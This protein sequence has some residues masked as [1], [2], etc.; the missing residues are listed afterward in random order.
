MN[1]TEKH[2]VLSGLSGF[3][4]FPLNFF[5]LLNRLNPVKRFSCVIR[6]TAVR[7]RHGSLSL[8]QGE[9]RYRR[10]RGGGIK[11]FFL[12]A[13]DYTARKAALSMSTTLGGTLVANYEAIVQK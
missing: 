4:R 12:L 1:V 5:C 9:D 2:I 7:L 10:R 6:Q 8:I 13:H 3:L 11:G